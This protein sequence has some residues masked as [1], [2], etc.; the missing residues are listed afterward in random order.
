MNN[1]DYLINL[2]HERL[3]DLLVQRGDPE[4]KALSQSD[5]FC[6]VLR[7]TAGGRRH[8]IPAPDRR[9]RNQ[10]IAAAIQS[11][12]DPGTVAERHGV[13]VKTVT[14]A[15]RRTQEDHDN[16]NNFGNSDWNLK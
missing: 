13:S 8:Y 1:R 14:R 16:N 2:I 12:D 15:A 7:E 11:G 4:L 5:E 9:P 6:E 10:S 3:F